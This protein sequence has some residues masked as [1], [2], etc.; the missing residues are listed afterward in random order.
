MARCADDRSDVSAQDRDWSWAQGGPIP[1][2]N[3]S[4]QEVFAVGRT[5]ETVSPWRRSPD[6]KYMILLRE[7]LPEPR[8]Q[9][10]VDIG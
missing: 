2:G 8:G 7:R 4:P 5:V 3:T 10:L 6:L 9:A 1:T